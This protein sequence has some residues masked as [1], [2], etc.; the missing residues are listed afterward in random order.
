VPAT[1]L[2]VLFI[3]NSF[4]ARNDL[5]GMIAALAA[6]AGLRFT[7]RLISVGGASLRTHWN[8]G[9]A[10]TAIRTGGY[11]TVVLQ[12]QS[13]LPI[14]NPGRMLENVRLFDAV[15]RDAGAKTA[16]YLTWARRHAPDTQQALTS[17]YQSAARETGALLVPAGVA[18]QKFLT[19]HDRPALHDRDGSH[20]T[21]AGTYLAAC[22][23]FGTLFRRTPV[24]LA[25]PV[26]SLAPAELKA[27]QQAAW[28]A[29]PS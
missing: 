27:L 21:P 3:G 17:A 23:F 4:T 15:V 10:A 9:D 18:W 28:A 14:K 22:V 5:P 11:D 19:R 1:S 7:H 6:G 20:P 13:T 16:L 25:T 24:G 2:N 8:K 12:E 26:A 29:L